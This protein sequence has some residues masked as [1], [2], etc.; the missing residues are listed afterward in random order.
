MGATPFDAWTRL[1]F[2]AMKLGM[3]AQAVIALRTSEMMQG[4]RGAER[5]LHRMVDE[6]A[7]TFV[8][9]CLEAQRA[10]LTAGLGVY[11]RKVSANQRRLSRRRR[12]K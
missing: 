11:G 8:A 10:M 1:A 2:S 5:E 6:K 3:D 7:T 4:G 9:A 12:R